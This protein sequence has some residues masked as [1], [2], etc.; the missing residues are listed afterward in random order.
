MGSSKSPPPMPEITPVELP[1]P[2]MQESPYAKG[3]AARKSSAAL[4]A[5]LGM[6]GTLISKRA[7]AAA[8]DAAPENLGKTLLGT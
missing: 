3:S 8:A 7:G 2:P 6:G 1:P 5:G 4:A